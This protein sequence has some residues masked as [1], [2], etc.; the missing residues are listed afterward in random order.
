MQS[1]LDAASLRAIAAATHG[2]YQALGPLGDG[3]DRSEDVE[4]PEGLA[5]WGSQRRN[6]V[7]RF[8]APVALGLGVLV[9]ES[10][11][12]TRRS[13]RKVASTRPGLAPARPGFC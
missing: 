4:Q 9:V 6:G 3:L 11:L 12:G 10:L 2:S 5:R 13:R 8:Q 1:R 7:D